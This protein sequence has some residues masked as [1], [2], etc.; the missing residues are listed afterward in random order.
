MSLFSKLIKHTVM[1]PLNVVSDVVTMGGVLNGDESALKKQ[2][3][4][5]KKDMDEDNNI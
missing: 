2:V 5:F 4:E 1:L 3:E